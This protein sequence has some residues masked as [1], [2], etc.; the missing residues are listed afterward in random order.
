MGEKHLH[1]RL[2]NKWISYILP[3][4][5]AVAATLIKVCCFRYTGYSIPFLLYFLVTLISG[6]VAGSRGV[7]TALLSI[8]VCTFTWLMPMTGR[9]YLL[10]ELLLFLVEGLAVAGL[11]WWNERAMKKLD[12]S[13]K[14]YRRITDQSAEALLLC[15][16]D[17]RVNYASAAA[18]RL[19]HSN[20]ANRFLKDFIHPDDRPQYDLVSLRLQ[21]KEEGT[22]M[23]VQ[24]MAC[25]ESNW[26][27][28]E[29]C[30]NN[31]LNDPLV[32]AMV[33]QLRDITHRVNQ[34][35][36]QEDFVN[37]ASHELKSPITAI[38]GFLQIATRRWQ[39]HQ[40][41]N[42]LDYLNRIQ[43]QTDKLLALID[44]MLNLTKIKAGELVYHFE[45]TDL[46]TC[47]R[48]AAEAV[49]A[50][51][52]ARNIELDIQ[53]GLPAVQADTTRIGQVITNLL[54]NALKYSSA[55]A[56]VKAT[57]Y[58]KEQQLEISVSDHGIGIP[59]DK[60][61]RVFDRFYRVDSL[62]KG[63]YEGLGLGLFIAAEIV[64]KHQGHIW[65]ESEEG[66]GSV[67]YFSIPV[68]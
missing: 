27:W 18:L 28:T 29:C 59:T 43:A 38:R 8:I 15:C 47:L 60:L 36:H 42:Q 6:A 31:L 44:D 17:D 51:T 19:L 32:S 68:R 7:I 58:Q 5:L 39:E 54:S 4:L 63:K 48:E 62:P 46:A 41:E 14:K 11:F 56:P 64:R 30:I 13:E 37:L 35:K 23:L 10:A 33:V 26:R 49:R 65:A 67:F 61:R 50:S 45:R 1:Y 52:P 20:P 3:P 22:A 2:N 34:E 40:R 53:G 57:L 24:R 21:L 12:D 16:K 55:A 66:K 9:H 25:G